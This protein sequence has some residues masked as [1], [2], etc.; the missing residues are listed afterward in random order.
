M[1]RKKYGFF[2][3]WNLVNNCIRSERRKKKRRRGKH[4]YS[5]FL[6][7]KKKYSLYYQPFDSFLVYKNFKCHKNYDLIN[8]SK[9]KFRLGLKSYKLKLIRIICLKSL[10]F[11][12]QRNLRSLYLD[13][14]FKFNI[15]VFPD[16]WLTDKPK[17]VRMGKGKG[18]KKFK[19]FFLKKGLDVYNFRYIKRYSN[20]LINKKLYI[21]KFNVFVNFLI[22]IL[23][24]KLSLK[25][26]IYKKII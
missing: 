23:K 22:K 4:L 15:S 3:K 7:R 6:S 24:G 19:V 13:K 1:F 8:V 5:L 9:T 10:K 18:E 14:L 16:Y 21:L 12:S 20:F 25:N 11:V 2:F 17:S 26:L